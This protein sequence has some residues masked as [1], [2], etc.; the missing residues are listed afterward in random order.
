MRNRL[1]IVCISLLLAACSIGPDYVRPTI[2]T[3][4]NW[5]ITYETAAGLADTTWWERFED[6]V[7]NDLIHAALKENLD[8]MAAAARVDQY[9][10]QLQ[11]TRA[12][13][14]PQIG[15]SGFAARQDET[16]TGLIPG[17]NT[18]YNYYEGTVNATWEID[19]WGRIRRASEAARAEMLASEEARRAVLLTLTANTAGSY[20]ALRGLDRQLEIA[21]DTEK[22]YAES[23]RIFNL[24]H[25][26]GTVSQLEVSQV[27]SQ[28]EV[29][30]QAVPKLE[31]QVARQEHLLCVLLGRNPG[32]IPRGKTIDEL[33]IPGIPAGLPSELLERRPDILQA[34]Q[35]LIAANA[36]IGVAR[37]LYFPRV[38]LTGAFG[39]ASIHSDQLFEGPSEVWQLTGNALMP[40][41]TFGA[42]EGQVQAAEARQRQALFNYRQAILNA[43]RDVEDALVSTTKGREQL[44]SQL[45]QVKA[46]GTY[47]YLAK[48]QYEAGKTSYLQVLDADRALFDGQLSQVRT[49]ASALAALVD[50]YRAMGGGWVDEADRIANPP[51][52]AQ[53]AAK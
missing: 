3:Q 14:F 8:L 38:S 21:R 22:V 12:E 23:L 17:D 4:P 44:G 32:L 33:A 36:R 35:Q 29:A 48:L 25:Q 43:F 40:I 39:T 5:R 51:Q 27:E 45:R 42:I 50:V 24:R 30:R 1:L 31:A 2:A 49:Q 19:I 26:Y 6:P 28:Y 15:A 7:L 13:F 20:I 10:G 53:A 37:A 16:E 18:P 46:L 9:L 47:A 11:T 52:T 34:E 41:F